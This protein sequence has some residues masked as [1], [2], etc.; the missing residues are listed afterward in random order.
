MHFLLASKVAA[1]MSIASLIPIPWELRGLLKN[2]W[3]SEI[4]QLCTLLC[5][6]FY[7]LF[8]KFFRPF[9]ME[10]H[11]LQCLEILLNDFIDNF[12]HSIFSSFFLDFLLFGCCTS[13]TDP[14]CYYIF[15]S[16]F[17]LFD[18]CFIFQKIS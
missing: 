2:S 6:S 18:F 7:S 16:T 10:V 9:N 5:P 17:H 1:T 11:V 13:W 4:S 14:L 15:Y 3:L 8:K 12:L